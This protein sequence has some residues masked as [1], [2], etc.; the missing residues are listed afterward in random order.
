MCPCV[1][2]HAVVCVCVCLCL[3]V[4]VCVCVCVVWCV[5]VC[6]LLG[7][8][9]VFQLT[10]LSHMLT[11][12]GRDTRIWKA[13]ASQNTRPSP[14]AMPFHHHHHPTHVHTTHTYTLSDVRSVQMQPHSLQAAVI[15]WF[16][17]TVA[18]K[19]FQPRIPLSF[20]LSSCVCLLCLVVIEA[21]SK[22]CG[23]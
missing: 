9:V 3:C 21:R 12:A 15:L 23:R 2:A 14:V 13:F 16:L 22:M 1:S 10:C 6:V 4:C 11:A 17:S 5:C 20:A 19:G 8:A 18:R 7:A